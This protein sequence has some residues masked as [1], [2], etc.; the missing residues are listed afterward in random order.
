MQVPSVKVLEF[1]ILNAS[2]HSGDLLPY[3]P[4]FRKLFRPLPENKSG[5]RLGAAVVPLTE[6]EAVTQTIVKQDPNQTLSF[7][8]DPPQD[9]TEEILGLCKDWTNPAWDELDWSKV[10]DM[11]VYETL[12]KRKRIAETAES[13]A[14]LRCP[15]FLKHVSYVRPSFKSA[16]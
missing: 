3:L 7:D 14:C 15:H 10:K 2:K 12:E 16:C 8:R 5:L 13:A 1:G 4:K 11:A 9:A 6:L